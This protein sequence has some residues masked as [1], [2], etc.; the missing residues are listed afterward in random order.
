MIPDD[1]GGI[2][3]DARD[4]S[5]CSFFVPDNVTTL[6][7]NLSTSGHPC[8]ESYVGLQADTCAN[9]FGSP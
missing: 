2:W 9:S 6:H 5:A 3:K 7:S 1:V 4:L 8:P